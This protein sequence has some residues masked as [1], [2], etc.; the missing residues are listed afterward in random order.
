M[1]TTFRRP[2]IHIQHGVLR[3]RSGRS[4]LPL[5]T[6]WG[7]FS[8]RKRA[9]GTWLAAKCLTSPTS[10]QFDSSLTGCLNP[11]RHR[12]H[13]RQSP[14][15]DLPFLSALL[16]TKVTRV[17]AAPARSPLMRKT[18]NAAVSPNTRTLVSE[19]RERHLKRHETV[20]GAESLAGRPALASPSYS[21]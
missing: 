11:S 21:L 17:R 9:S 10:Y 8:A 5:T 2:V 13:F 3:L 6:R 12:L 19:G 4:Y 16:H 20:C 7:V 15:Y 1:D 14:R 18:L